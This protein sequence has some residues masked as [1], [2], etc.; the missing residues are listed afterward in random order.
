[1]KDKVKE[2]TATI[3]FIAL[4]LTLLLIAGY[5]ISVLVDATST[6]A[7]EIKTEKECRDKGYAWH[8]VDGCF[9]QER[10]RDSYVD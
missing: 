7:S 9:T 6:H 4:F 10:F 8:A 5:V 2:I 1:M 3:G